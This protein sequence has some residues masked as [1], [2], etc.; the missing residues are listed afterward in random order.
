MRF[1]F[2]SSP[3]S[4]H[5]DENLTHKDSLAKINELFVS[6]I[7]D[8]TFLLYRFLFDSIYLLHSDLSGG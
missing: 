6:Q 1:I 8:S 7:A 2:L 3:L 4:L 5:C